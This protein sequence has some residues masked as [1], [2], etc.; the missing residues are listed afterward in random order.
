MPSSIIE[1]AVDIVEEMRKTKPNSIL[2]LGCGFGKWGFLAREYLDI[3][4]MRIKKE[5]WKVF[6][7]GVEICK[8]Y[9]E[10][11]G[12]LTEIYDEIF[13]GDILEF[14]E[15]NSRK[16][17]LVLANDVIEHLEKGKALD[18]FLKLPEVV[19]KSLILSIPIGKK[20]LNANLDWDKVNK[21]K[22]HIS[23]WEV[24]EVIKAMRSLNFH[25]LKLYDGGR[26]DVALF[27][28]RR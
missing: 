7:K 24:D 11:W 25:T 8:R 4:N 28:F 23:S 6:I 26:G 2:D 15:I 20:W 19:N 22:R 13:V 21:Y 1:N 27:I 14:L 12:H 17:D 5:D 18:V 9:V 16:Y 10:S 3:W